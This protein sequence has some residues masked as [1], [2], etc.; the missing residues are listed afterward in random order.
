MNKEAFERG[1]CK[2]ASEYNID[3]AVLLKEASA[4]SMIS[5]LGPKLMHMMQ[6]GGHDERMVQS[7]AHNLST[8]PGGN[9]GAPAWEFMQ[10]RRM[11]GGTGDLDYF[12]QNLNG[13]R[14]GG[15]LGQGSFGI[16]K[17]PEALNTQDIY[18]RLISRY[19]ANAPKGRWYGSSGP[20]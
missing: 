16:D 20:M 19:G 12:H 15:A 6:Q 13:A 2:R 7:A 5:E 14:E 9:E 17:E 4:G 11:P 18:Q 8:I 3:G 1:F 10:S